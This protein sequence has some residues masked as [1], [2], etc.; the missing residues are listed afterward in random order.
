MV[1]Y[2]HGCKTMKLFLNLWKYFCSHNL[3]NIGPDQTQNP[4]KGLSP[5]PDQTLSVSEI[6]NRLCSPTLGKDKQAFKNIA[7]LSYLSFQE[8]VRGDFILSR[9]VY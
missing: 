9:C 3:G 5:G 7:F 1:P 2:S 4:A 8:M 6:Q